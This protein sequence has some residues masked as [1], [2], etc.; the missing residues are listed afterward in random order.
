MCKLKEIENL[1]SMVQPLLDAVDFLHSATVCEASEQGVIVCPGGPDRIKY[2]RGIASR[3]RRLEASA[4]LYR[5]REEKSLQA[6]V[7]P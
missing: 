4:R 2:F 5:S 1:A 7:L 6:A 3:L